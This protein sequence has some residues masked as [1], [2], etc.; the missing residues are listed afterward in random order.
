MRFHCSPRPRARLRPEGAGALGTVP[1]GPAP[2]LLA[3]AAV[4]T[5]DWTLTL[6]LRAAGAS[7]FTVRF[8]CALCVWPE[9]PRSGLKQ[10]LL[11]I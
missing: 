1:Q 8:E 9:Q 11:T 7:E 4:A 2:R 6:N 5:F 3:R 10:Q